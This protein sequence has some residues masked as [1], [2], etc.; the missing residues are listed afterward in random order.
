MV[1]DVHKLVLYQVKVL[2]NLEVRSYLTEQNNTMHEGL[3]IHHH[4]VWV[5]S[6]IVL[7]GFITR[8]SK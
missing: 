5:V 4:H 2:Y 6:V 3:S 8:E 7:Q 1:L